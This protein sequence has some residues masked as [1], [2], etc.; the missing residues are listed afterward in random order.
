MGYFLQPSE[1][2][3]EPFSPGCSCHQ[4]QSPSW[5]TCKREEKVPLLHG[6]GEKKFLEVPQ[7]QDPDW[8]LGTWLAWGQTQG[9]HWTHC[10]VSST[11]PSR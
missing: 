2:I 7:E 8:L 11:E 10:L 1:Q 5:G 6:G 3:R 4:W 9:M